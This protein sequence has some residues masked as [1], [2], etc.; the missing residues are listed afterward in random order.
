M[1]TQILSI[2][3]L[4]SVAC[5]SGQPRHNPHGA[6]PPP[7]EAHHQDRH[8][9]HRPHR[10]TPPPPPPPRRDRHHDR[11]HHPHGRRVDILCV[12]D[13]QQLWNGC[14]VRVNQFGVSILDRRDRRIIRGDEIILLASGDYKVRSGGFWRIYNERGDRLVNVW[15]DSIELMRDGL[16]CCIR[17]G[18]SHY[19]DLNGNERH[20]RSF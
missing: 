4:L 8:G 20:F 3:L 11:D 1:K 15:G 13:W 9:H 10:E 14:H 2:A 5:A 16:Y 17:A 18:I 7:P 12:R 6:P 19:Y